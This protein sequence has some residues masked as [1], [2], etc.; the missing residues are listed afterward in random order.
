MQPVWRM[1][2]EIAVLM[3]RAALDQ[4]AAPK[5]G[6]S[7]LETRR[8]IDND[9]FGRLQATIDEIV[10]KRPPG[11]FALPSHV[12]DRQQ[13]FLAGRP[14]PREAKSTWPSCRAEPAPP[15]RRE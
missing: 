12:L 14:A 7:F 3:N 11:C 4:H 8:A 15:C 6:K 10:E 2:E 1:P 13:H 9:E 5:R